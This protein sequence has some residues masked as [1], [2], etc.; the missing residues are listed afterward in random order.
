MTF[1]PTGGGHDQSHTEPRQAV[2]VPGECP[3]P[4]SQS[5]HV[6][7]RTRGAKLFLFSLR[8]VPRQGGERDVERLYVSRMPVLSR[9]RRAILSIRHHRPGNT[10]TRLDHPGGF[11]HFADTVPRDPLR[12]AVD[13]RAMPTSLPDFNLLSP[14]I[15]NP[16][17][18][19]PAYRL[20]A[21]VR[22]GTWER[23]PPAGNPS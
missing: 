4:R 7:G 12:S 15:E 17:W 19:R 23:H 5:H 3:P 21:A 6:P 2:S 11:P 1:N 9:P 14:P 13:Q 8:Q 20:P 16:P 10:E 22:S 18:N